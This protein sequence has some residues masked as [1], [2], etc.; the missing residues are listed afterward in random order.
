MLTQVALLAVLGGWNSRMAP[1]SYAAPFVGDDSRI[2]LGRE[3]DQ[4]DPAIQPG[5]APYEWAN[6]PPLNHPG[7]KSKS[8]TG[9]RFTGRYANYTGADT[10]YPTWAPDGHLYSAWTDGYIWTKGDFPATDCPFCNPPGLRLSADKT[11]G[12]HRLYHCHSNVPPFATGQAR[13]EGDHPLN[14]EVINLGKMA[15]GRDLYPCVMTVADGIFYIGTYEAFAKQGRFS[16]YR[17]S[18]Q[19]NHWAEE[20]TEGWK[21]SQG[22]VNTTTPATDFW[23][24][25]TAP[26][27]FNVPHGVVFGQDNQLSP[28]GK[29]YL[30]AHGSIAGG[31]SDWDKGD[32]IYLSR[33][34]SNP[35]SVSNPGAYEF[36]TGR[37]AAGDPIWRQDVTQAAPILE[38]PGH[39]GSE[40]ITYLP[41][42]N[43]Y[44]LMSARLKE[45][46]QNLPYNV[47]SFWEAD[48]ITGPYRLVHYLRDWGPQTYF[49]NIPTK[50]ISPD[51]KSMW[52]VVSSNYSTSDKANPFGA[53]Y[54]MSMHE[55]ALDIADEPRWEEPDRD[56]LPVAVS[57]PITLPSEPQRTPRVD[58][59]GQT[60]SRIRLWDDADPKNWVRRAE[61]KFSTGET[62]VSRAWLSPGGRAAG[63]VQLA[64]PIRADWAEISITQGSGTP[65]LSKIEFF[66]R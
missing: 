54:A 29:I 41:Q 39:L 43:K 8:I 34:A 64:K 16:G 60:V 1:D 50:F 11:V 21:E 57:G 49:P 7:E 37:D 40:S 35:E 61:I 59:G 9:I 4:L 31:S 6:D 51:G 5:Y 52:L 56:R 28:D 48:E 45:N 62:V 12:A 36:F 26:R 17:Y 23:A 14:L 53:R 47:L 58:L 20:L 13:I 46:E 65:T 10:F 3:G 25:D 32:A 44:L 19:W 42:L 55:I 63:E 24:N 66:A 15:S 38:W 22:W 30:S 18:R 2:S 33:V 27:R